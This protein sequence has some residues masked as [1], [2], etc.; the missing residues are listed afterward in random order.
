[1]LRK[2][3]TR[4]RSLFT[5]ERMEQDLD[6]ELSFHLDM[7][8]EQQVRRGVPPDEARRAALQHF[9]AVSGVKDAVR[10]TWLS[11]TVETFAQDI[12]YG[13][14]NIRRTPGFALVVIVTMALGIGA[15]TAIFSVVNAVLLRPLPYVHGDQLVVLRQQRPTIGV[16]DDGFS[17]TDIADYARQSTA[18]DAIG[19][20]HTMW[21][22]LLG[23]SEPE[24][25]STGVVSANYFQM[26][27]IEPMLGRAFADRDEQHGAPAVLIL[28]HK[29]WK[30]SF[31][32]DPTVIGRVFEMNDRPHEVIGV[33]PPVP[34]YPEDA[35]VYMPTSACPFRS[36]ERMRTVRDARMVSAVG[37]IREGVALETARAD[38]DVVAKR[39]QRDYPD[40]Y[41]AAQGYRI[42]ATP[43]QDELTRSFKTTLLVLLGTA[44]FVLL[45]VCASVA[46]LTLARMVRRDREMAVRA[47]LGASRT[48]LVRQLLTESTLLAVIGGALGL[49]I[50]GWGVQL[51][52]AFAERYTTR[53][54]EISID[55]AVLLFTLVVSVATGLIFGAVPAFARRLG[56]A[57]SAL[58]AGGRSTHGAHSVRA[59]LIVAQVAVSFMLLIGAGLTV[60]TLFN[61]QQVDPGVQ[62]DDVLT[63]RL[64]LNFT[65]YANRESRA[66]FW[67]RLDERFRALPG[68]FS[69]GGAGT[70]PLNEQGP[71][72]STITLEGV[73]YDTNAQR[74]RVDVR[75]VSPGYFETLKQPVLSG[76][77]FQPSDRLGSTRV[78]IVGKSMAQRFWPNENPIGRRIS[79]DNGANWAT[80]IGVVA[81][82]RQQLNR[83]PGD[84]LYIPMFQ[85][86]QLTSNWLIRTNVDAA[87]MTRQVREAIYS[88]DPN[89]P[90]DRFR[91][92]ADVRASTLESP[93]LTAILIGLFA[94]LA[95]VITAAGM[96][97][98][99][100]FSVN[101]R[102]QEFGVRMALGAQRTDVLSM[103][104][105]QGLRLVLVGLAIGLGGALVLA[106]LMT[107]LLFGVEPTDAPTFVVVSMVLVAVAALACFVPARRAASV[108]PMIA[109]RVSMFLLAF[110]GVA[111]AQQPQAAADA[112]DGVDTVVLLTQGKEAFGK[113]QFSTTYGRFTY[114]FTSAETKAQFDKAP[115]RFAI[116]MG[117]LCARM[118]KT[119]TG[120]PGDY[121]VHDGKIYIFGS[122]ACHKAFVAAPDKYLP[123][124]PAP[125]PT[126][127][128]AV[129]RGRALLD[130]AA[131]AVGDLSKLTSY[132]DTASQTQ[133]R[134]TGDVTMVT[135]TFWRFPGDARI[136]RRMSRPDGMAMMFGTML[137]GSGAWNVGPQGMSPVVREAIPSVQLDFGR[138]IVPVLRIRA[139]PAT[140]IAALGAA[141]LDGVA[142]ERVR[143][144]RGA[145]D[146]T[147]NIDPATGRVHS[148]TFVDRG[149]TGEIG[150]FTIAYSDFRNVD[151]YMLPFKESGTFNGA[152]DA[153]STRTLDSIALNTPLE[154]TLFTP[155]PVKK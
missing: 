74:P 16:E 109:L 95:L 38:L 25:V 27:G 139:D 47:A 120:N 106:R 135:K 56:E 46:N 20:F 115:E 111:S 89:Q 151:G 87:T 145:V 36:S 155:P 9:G 98:V 107:T 126:A 114:L 113:S 68:V 90:A 53:A 58:R 143:V 44:G 31:G 21:F 94:L 134:P 117:G 150:E 8:T 80:V 125:M 59:G 76:R 57:A 24:R 29:Y 148:T 127:A 28:S 30:T 42:T 105:R 6:R 70:F 133:R 110:A 118:G 72:T 79:G 5:R 103:V 99:I 154:S 86:G 26:L 138:Q 149:Q 122:D 60:R 81:D 101:Q 112:L 123:K 130:K 153:A 1:M 15:N 49:A 128:D 19:E 77:A 147:L 64:D 45:I 2:I 146:V 132:V 37:R 69:V 33:L 88:V 83:A 65:K 18:L 66:A 55:R 23:R 40:S 82:A 62:T 54:Q 119:V 34:Q 121:A 136:E 104:L 51:L 71:F 48:R 84:E 96:A 13:L 124:P 3:S 100:A 22:I 63:M 141:S 73:Q 10:E 102:T 142:V 14:R 108:D 17:A 50:A 12:R 140:K 39:L 75:L 116:Q 52:S 85:S 11:R 32:G 93:K 137:N 131:A 43:L 91:T 97:G 144:R 152:A 67:Q 92:L 41:Q 61:L 7:L 35:D 78:V 129:R 4:V